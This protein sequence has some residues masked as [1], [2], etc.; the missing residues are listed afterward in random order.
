MLILRD[1]TDRILLEQSLLDSQAHAQLGSWAFNILTEEIK[2]SAETFRI[3]DLYEN[4]KPPEFEV[5][6]SMVHE[7]DQKV[8]RRVIAR[9]IIDKE[10][11]SIDHRIITAKGTLKWIQARGKLILD[12]DGRVSHLQGTIQDI[13]ERK[14]YEEELKTRNQ[15]LD[16]FV[17][18]IS[19][20]LRSP[21]CTIQG[22]VN[23][24]HDDLTTNQHLEYIKLIKSTINKLF[25]FI[26]QTLSHSENINTPIHSHR[27]DFESIIQD[28]SYSYKQMP[29]WA[30]IKIETKVSV[31]DF[32]GDIES[33]LQCIALKCIPIL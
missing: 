16:T 28:V 24:F 21:I 29:A 33:D 8:I 4:T 7:K 31:H 22:L 2:W 1:N 10:P 30:Y 11:Y 14:N 23:M 18:R 27:L 5:Y 17:Y 25:V 13:T 15:E 9:A 20:D 26:D 3:F 12:E 6:L 32:Y 19:H